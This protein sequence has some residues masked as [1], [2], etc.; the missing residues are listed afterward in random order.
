MGDGLE[1][2]LLLATT[3]LREEV[4][5]PWHQFVYKHERH[6]SALTGP[7]YVRYR[8]KPD[9]LPRKANEDLALG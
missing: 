1:N 6:V 9:I 3:G 8:S 5:G 4:R 2:E 7:A